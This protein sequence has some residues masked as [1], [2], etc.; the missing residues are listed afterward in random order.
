MVEVNS[1]LQ[2]YWCQDK[3]VS[4]EAV[5]SGLAAPLGVDA[6]QLIHSDEASQTLRAYTKEAAE[7]G[8]FGVPG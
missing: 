4:D 6:V 5:L 1:L 2:A 7:R 8:A 3:D